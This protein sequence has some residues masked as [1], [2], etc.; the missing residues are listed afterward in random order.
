MACGGEAVRG[1]HPV[2]LF[3][4]DWAADDGLAAQGAPPVGCEGDDH[5]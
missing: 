1:M 5:P 3:G 4:E 2:E